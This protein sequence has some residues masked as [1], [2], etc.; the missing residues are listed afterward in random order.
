[1]SRL[2]EKYANKVSKKEEKAIQKAM[3]EQ[4]AS[5]DSFREVDM[6]FLRFCQR[7]PYCK[8]GGKRCQEG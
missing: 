3:D 6:Q 1:M 4:K 8:K 5:R 7:C 2:S